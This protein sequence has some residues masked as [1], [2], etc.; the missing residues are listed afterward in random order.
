MSDQIFIILL[1][2]DQELLSY[3]NSEQILK[4]LQNTGP[5]L[6][7]ISFFCLKNDKI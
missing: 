5:T 7:P 4:F 2:D 6:R 1:T 3:P